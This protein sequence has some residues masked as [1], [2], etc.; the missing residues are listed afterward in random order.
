MGPKIAKFFP[1]VFPKF[2][3]PPHPPPRGRLPLTPIAFPALDP[4]PKRPIPKRSLYSFSCSGKKRAANTRD[5]QKFSFSSLA[6]PLP[7]GRPL[8]VSV[9]LLYL[10]HHAS[11]YPVTQERRIWFIVLVKSYPSHSSLGRF[12]TRRGHYL[13]FFLPGV[14]RSKVTHAAPYGTSNSHFFRLLLG[15]QVSSLTSTPLQLVSW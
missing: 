1:F 3:C 12:Y 8:A 6:P 10:T 14:S 7:P 2:P 11:L 9:P 5:P 13:S 4:P 15:K